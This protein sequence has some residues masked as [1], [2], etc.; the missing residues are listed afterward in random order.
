MRITYQGLWDIMAKRKMTKSDL[1][2]RAG[3]SI[4]TIRVMARGENV[5]LDVLGK[6]CAALH[7]NLGNI[8]RFVE[9]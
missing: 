7:V 1:A 8:A 2:Q 5:S 3:I 6:I 4:S 9:E